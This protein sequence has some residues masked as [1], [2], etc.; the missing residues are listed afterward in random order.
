MTPVSVDETYMPMLT[1]P[2]KLGQS[3][4]STHLDRSLDAL[5]AMGSDGVNGWPLD[6]LQI[7]ESREVKA[8]ILE[9]VGG[10]VDE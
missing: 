8:E 7:T 9:S 1:Q 10:L 5:E 4:M 3:L 6:Q 2:C